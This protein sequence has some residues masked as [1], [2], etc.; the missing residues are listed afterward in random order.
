MAS[1]GK[2][3]L[4]VTLLAWQ[5]ANRWRDERGVVYHRPYNRVLFLTCVLRQTLSHMQYL[6]TIL[7]LARSVPGR[8]DLHD[9]GHIHFT[10]IIRHCS[11]YSSRISPCAPQNA[12][13]ERFRLVPVVQRTSNSYSADARNPYSFQFSTQVLKPIMETNNPTVVAQAQPSQNK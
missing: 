4:S 9:L 6:Q 5:H 12:D 13:R 8:T 3:R 7:V 1:T 10:P 11:R 2:G